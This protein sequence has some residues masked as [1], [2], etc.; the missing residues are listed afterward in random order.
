MSLEFLKIKVDGKQV[1][2]ILADDGVLCFPS[3]LKADSKVTMKGKPVTLEES[4]YD[5]RD[6][7]TYIRTITITNVIQKPK[8]QSD[9]KS[10][11]GSS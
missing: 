8:E 10:N 4:W 5:Q 3:K 9:D 6:G 11:E 1:D 7:V 2:G